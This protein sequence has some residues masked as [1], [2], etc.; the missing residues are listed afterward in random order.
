MVP[1]DQS[2]PDSLAEGGLVDV[3]GYRL[4]VRRAGTGSPTVVFESGGGDNSSVWSSVEPEVRRRSSV[5]TFLYDRAGLGR[6]EPKS[7]PYRI[8]DEVTAL[9]R[10]LDARAIDGPL[11]LVAHSYG[12]FVSLL[13]AETDPR[14]AGLVLVDGN[15]PGFFDDPQVE[16]LLA[17]LPPHIDELRRRMPDLSR[18]MV[19]ITLALPETARRVRASTLPLSLPV[20]DLVAERTW[21]EAPAEVDAM[22]RAHAAFVAA[23]PA[24][25]AVAARESGHYIMRERPELVVKATTRLIERVRATYGQEAPTPSSRP[26]NAAGPRQAF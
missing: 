6:S 23:S 16:R 21:V 25:E 8:D 20:V 10:A 2:D 4:W 15:L 17:R 1:S 18:V 19:P 11:V 5:A 9:R 7:G 13:T 14:V 3:G 24:R 26:R 12:A 22:R